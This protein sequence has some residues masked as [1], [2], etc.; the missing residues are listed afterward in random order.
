[1]NIV[2]R[3]HQNHII[4]SIVRK[5]IWTIAKM[6]TLFFL[7]L[8][9]IMSFFFFQ[10]KEI[11]QQ[12]IMGEENAVQW[13]GKVQTCEIKFE[14]AAYYFLVAH[15]MVKTQKQ[16]FICFICSFWHT[17]K[18]AIFE[19]IVCWSGDMWCQKQGKRKREEKIIQRR[20]EMLKTRKA[21]MKQKPQ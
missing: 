21:E 19:G 14:F 4:I 1:M 5:S 11:K 20:C 13:S 12:N 15:Q 6:C 18:M 3:A 16:V 9:K 10:Q 2:Q 17:K 8:S 7:F